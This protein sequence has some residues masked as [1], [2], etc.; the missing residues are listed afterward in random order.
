M[1]HAPPASHPLF[2]EL[3]EP[4]TGEAVFD[5][6]ADLVYFVKDAAGRYVVANRT[7]VDRCAADGKGDLLGR[8]AADLFPPPLGPR[9]LAQDLA[10][11]RTGV[12][13]TDELELHLY[14]SGAAGWCLTTK[15]PLR[16]RTG[17]WVGLVGV[18]KDVQPPADLMAGDGGAVAEYDA[19]AAAVGHARDNP[20]APA[21]LES[22]AGRSGLSPYQFD[23][24]VRRVFRLSTGQLLL[25]FRMDRATHRLRATAD[26][27]AV[28]AADC[29]YA[30]QSAFARQFRKT[31][32]LTPG[33]YRRAYAD[34]PATSNP[35]R[36]SRP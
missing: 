20:A 11:V 32:G 29:G 4:L 25:K 27:V 36:P 18:S 1:A 6:L 10:I 2:A 17:G 26:P 19:V 5:R 8:T 23:Q 21:T 35:P 22:L 31:A 28:V 34:P 15:L 12:P 7:L 9:Y 24:R 16:G 30:D 14:P 33:E 13:L 3:A